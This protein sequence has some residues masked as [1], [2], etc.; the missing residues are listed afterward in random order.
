MKSNSLYIA[1]RKKCLAN[2]GL[3]INSISP[4]MKKKF[5]HLTKHHTAKGKGYRKKSTLIK[6]TIF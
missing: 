4:L 1:E 6:P 2:A 5:H 3:E